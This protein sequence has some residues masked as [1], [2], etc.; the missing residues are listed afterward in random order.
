MRTVYFLILG[1]LY[2][3]SVCQY[4]N[5]R[6]SINFVTVISGLIL[7]LY[8]TFKNPYAVADG[9]NYIDALAGSK[10]ILEP[11]FNVLSD[12][13]NTYLN[14][15]V[16]WLFFI[17][18][19]IAITCKL[20]SISILS[21]LPIFC[22]IIWVTD[23]YPLHELGQI[24]AA[25]ATGVF[26]LSLKSLYHRQFRIYIVYTLIA[27]L[28]HFSAFLMIALIPLSVKKINIRIWY[29]AV[30]ISIIWAVMG[31]DIISVMKYIPGIGEDK[32]E[33]YLSVQKSLNN[34]S[35]FSPI[36]IGKF[37]ITIVLLLRVNLLQKHNKYAILLLKIILI[38]T[39]ARFIFASNV[40]I[41]FRISEFF[42]T[43]EIILFPMLIYLFKQKQFGYFFIIT[44][45]F[46][47][48]L[49][50]IFSNKLII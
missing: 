45:S 29:F 42:G 15:D 16:T 6:R 49:I 47:F 24:R 27:T 12:I 30:F 39:I 17:Y 25:A 20:Q 40:S 23:F 8:A 5:D 48:V 18:S 10:I 4:F 3:G 28:L 33:A 35:V 19:L 43:V 46:I 44:I 34:V 22:L 37:L 7:L 9:Q 13:I 26:L 50:R 11:T 21:K 32:Y 14:R 1:F 36:V 38:S 41:A 2:I 31:L